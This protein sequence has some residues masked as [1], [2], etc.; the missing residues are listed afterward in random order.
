MSPYHLTVTVHLLAALLWLGGMF[1]LAV[2]GAPV[3][4]RIEPPSLRVQLFQALGTRFRTVGWI[5]IAVLIL[6]GTLNVWFRGFLSWSTL[7]DPA[8]WATSWGSALGWKLAA[9]TFM[10]LN[11]AVH[12]VWLGP[13]AGRV[14][15]GTPE[16]LRYRAWA[17]WLARLNAIVGILLVVVAVRL[18]RGG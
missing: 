9:V 6:T 10:V 3:L 4:R 16:A 7:S 15:P 18:A 1:F 2:V 13:A 14:R 11:S 17:S 8:F 12:D 5:A